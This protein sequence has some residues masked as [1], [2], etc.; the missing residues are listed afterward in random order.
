MVTD[1]SDQTQDPYGIK[2]GLVPAPP[3]AGASS[4][5]TEITIRTMANDLAML[6]QTGGTGPQ[7]TTVAISFAHPEAGG[8]KIG[9]TVTEGGKT[10]LAPLTVNARLLLWVA[11]GIVGAAILFAGGYYAFPL[12]F[13]TNA[14]APAAP[15]SGSRT[16]TGGPGIGALPPGSTEKIFLGHVS[17]FGTGPDAGFEARI[18]A[19][20]S[21][22]ELQTFEQQIASG[23]AG[24]AS[25]AEFFEVTVKNADGN[26]PA[27]TEFLAERGAELT[28]G[29]AFTAAFEQDFTMFAHRDKSG[30]W[31]GFVLRIKQGTSP[32]AAKNLIQPIEANPARLA[33]LYLA[34]PG[35]ARGPFVDSQVAGQPV[36]TGA[37][38][39]SGAAFSYGVFYSKFVILST[40]LDGLRAAL[41]RL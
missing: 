21:A 13:P 37:F 40:S 14:P 33:S 26:Q 38:S 35:T 18:G 2:R 8:G 22:G 15:G 11:L 39:A 12:L 5:L 34:D 30:V 10:A 24:A 25:D 36:R 27:L 31:P 7:G 1:P 6:G 16:G 29:N 3:E 23:V 19:A 41:L 32:I 28:S 17:A 9:V 20:A 4:S